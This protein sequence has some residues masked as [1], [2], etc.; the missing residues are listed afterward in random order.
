MLI[1]NKQ[2]A[3]Y[4]ATKL[5]KYFKDFNRI[6]DYFRARKIERVK[7]IPQ[8]MPEECKVKNDPIQG[9]KNYYI[10]YKNGFANWKNRTKPEWYKEQNA[11]IH[12]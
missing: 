11:N 9:Y 12:I 10:N 1:L 3:I 5:I 6:D 2:D 8:A 4:S 7:N